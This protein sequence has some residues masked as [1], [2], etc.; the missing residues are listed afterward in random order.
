MPYIGQCAAYIHIRVHTP[1]YPGLRQAWWYTFTRGQT[2]KTMSTAKPRY[3]D[4][5]YQAAHDDTFSY[6]L[7]KLETV[8]PPGIGQEDFAKLLSELV[9]A[10]EQNAVFSGE[11]LKD[12]VDPYDIPEA[13]TQKKVPSAAVW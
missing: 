2:Y 6:P 7:T 9:Q 8:L 3:G 11:S 13:G 1:Q 12:Y 10:T 4:P 5:E